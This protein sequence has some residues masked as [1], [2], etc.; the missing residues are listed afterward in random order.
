MVLREGSGI[1][2]SFCVNGVTVYCG[3]LGFSLCVAGMEVY[4]VRV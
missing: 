3:V 1:G 2:S 4:G